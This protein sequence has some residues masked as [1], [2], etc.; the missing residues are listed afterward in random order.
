MRS[1]LK[2]VYGSM[3]ITPAQWHLPIPDAI[4]QAAWR[5]SQFCATPR[6]QW[7]TY[8][9]Q[10]CSDILMPLLREYQ[11]RASFYPR[12]LL[13][14]WDMIPGLGVQGMSKRF[15]VIPDKSLDRILS[16]PQE[17]I[18]SPLWAG[19]YYLAVQINPDE[20]SLTVWGYATHAM[21]KAQGEYQS[22]RRTYDLAP[23]HLIQDLNVLWVT[24]RLNPQEVTQAPIA[25]I[26]AIDHAE[27]LLQ[28]LAHSPQPRLD[29]PF[30]QWMAC[31]HQR[32]WLL[33]LSAL[34]RGEAPD[35]ATH[36]SQWFDN[37]FGPDWFALKDQLTPKTDLVEWRKNLPVRQAKHLRLGNH[38]LLF[39]VKIMILEDDRLEILMQLRSQDLRLILPP[40]MTVKLFSSTGEILQSAEAGED[41]LA[42]QLYRF[43][44]MLGT[45][46]SVRF[47]LGENSIE[48]QF[49]V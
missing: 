8:L 38:A 22:N 30:A 7:N 32:D 33:R 20:Q 46:F 2:D 39:T 41:D 16:L 37:V 17:W 48:E 1:H 15:V 47:A 29:V 13:C 18:D 26:P 19:D 23:E 9:N 12:D 10:L 28:T 43:R 25:P 4:A 31:L 11:P 44:A 36:L 35:Y 45:V 27:Q 5:Q 40:D 14:L 21:V 24:H 34:R 3:D 6:A 42:L 49:M